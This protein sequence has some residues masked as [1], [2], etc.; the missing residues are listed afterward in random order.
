VVS[1][2][3]RTEPLPPDRRP[4]P[5]VAVYDRLLARPGSSG[6]SDQEEARDGRSA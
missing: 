4:A 2:A 5:A 1:L 3:R 6:D